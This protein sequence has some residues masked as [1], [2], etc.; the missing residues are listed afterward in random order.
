[1]GYYS[2]L[3]IEME[4]LMMKLPDHSYLSPI[5]QLLMRIDDLAAILI[6]YNSQQ[7]KN[8]VDLSSL[9]WS[10][11]P[12]DDGVFI[13]DN[14]LRYV[15]PEHITSISDVNRALKLAVADYTR[16]F[17]SEETENVPESEPNTIIGQLPINGFFEKGFEEFTE[18]EAA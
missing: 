18:N 17:E 11:V 14:D 8:C 4:E 6:S 2:N 1:M 7:H 10:L 15:L 12:L 16:L 13:G 3:S 9:G 5:E